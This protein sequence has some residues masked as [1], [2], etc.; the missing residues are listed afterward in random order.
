[1]GFAPEGLPFGRYETYVELR[2][3]DEHYPRVRIPVTVTLLRPQLAVPERLY[4]SVGPERRLEAHVA[5]LLAEADKLTGV[6]VTGLPDGFA[7]SVEENSGARIADIT[8]SSG[9]GNLE[10][11]ALGM[12]TVTCDVNGASRTVRIP[13]YFRVA[14]SGSER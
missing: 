4:A 1:M 6:E 13:Y 2:T 14:T 3:D 11:N 8:L 12:M 7:Y 5:I 9:S 10:R